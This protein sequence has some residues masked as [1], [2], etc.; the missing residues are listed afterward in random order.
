MLHQGLAEERVMGPCGGGPW[1]I[2]L[3]SQGGDMTLGALP[4]HVV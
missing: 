1:P 3:V 2:Y 4:R